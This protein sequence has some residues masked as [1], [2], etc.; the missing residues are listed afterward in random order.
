MLQDLLKSYAI[1]DKQISYCQGMNYSMGFLYLNLHDP[2]IAFKCFVRKMDNYLRDM[3]DNE[4]DLLKKYF[5]KF[6][7]LMEI[8]IPDLAAHFEVKALNHSNLYRER[9]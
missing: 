8:F 4:F 1:Y 9:R 2:D 7:R 3:F 6:K 5:F